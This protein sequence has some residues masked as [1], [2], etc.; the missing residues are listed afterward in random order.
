MGSFRFPAGLGGK[1]ATKS[2]LGYAPPTPGVLNKT[3]GRIETKRRECHN[4]QDSRAASLSTRSSSP[5]LIPVGVVRGYSRPE[6]WSFQPDLDYSIH[7]PPS[8]SPLRLP[9]CPSLLPPPVPRPSY[10]E[11]FLSGFAIG[12]LK[13][14]T[15]EALMN[16]RRD[17]FAP[18][19]RYPLTGESFDGG[20]C[21]NTRKGRINLGI[22]VLF[23]RPKRSH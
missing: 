21:R 3:R 9:L 22:V 7:R 11:S 17:S 10:V 18:P 2:M 14:D 15:G 23:G 13:R 4:Y 16:L 6:S 8:G 5:A 1:L 20:R 19:G 12:V